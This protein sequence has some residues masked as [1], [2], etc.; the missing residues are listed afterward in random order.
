MMDRPASFRYGG[1]LSK[2]LTFFGQAR[3]N[4]I[5]EWPSGAGQK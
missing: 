4:R 1:T 3:M 5:L 2:A